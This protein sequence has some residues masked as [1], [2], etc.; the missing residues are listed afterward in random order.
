MSQKKIIK[1]LVKKIIKQQENEKFGQ[2][3]DDFLSKETT[4]F[5]KLLMKYNFSER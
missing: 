1:K 2:L 3:S 5:Q 4:P